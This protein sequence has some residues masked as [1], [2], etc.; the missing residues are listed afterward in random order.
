MARP[1]KRRIHMK[2]VGKSNL[3]SK[4]QWMLAGQNL[5]RKTPRLIQ[6]QKTARGASTDDAGSYSDSN[7]TQSSEPGVEP[8]DTELGDPQ[9]GD[10]LGLATLDLEVNRLLRLEEME[11]PNNA[12]LPI[13]A[14]T[15]GGPGP[16]DLENNGNHVESA[17]GT[18]T[19]A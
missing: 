11:E 10:G 12:L 5:K 4:C 13:L 9:R 18:G 17:S 15:R 6:F 16:G 1:S 2:A 8:E 7:S 3:K 19:S 14:S